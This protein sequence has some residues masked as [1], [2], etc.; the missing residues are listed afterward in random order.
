M[1][2]AHG[3]QK[4]NTERSCISGTAR[5]GISALRFNHQKKSECLGEYGNSSDAE[6]VEIDRLTCIIP[7][8]LPITLMRLRD[9]VTKPAVES[10]AADL[11][12][13]AIEQPSER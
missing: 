11:I 4:N 9:D 7:A 8:C 6:R 2:S 1:P 10:T 5:T 12:D 13:A 3:Q